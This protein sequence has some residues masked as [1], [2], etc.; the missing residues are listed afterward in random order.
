M[1]MFQFMHPHRKCDLGGD[2][3][4]AL[5]AISTR[6]P[7]TG[8]DSRYP[9]SRTQPANFNSRT[10]YGGDGASITPHAIIYKISIKFFNS[11]IHAGCAR[12]ANNGGDWCG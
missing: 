7:H 10:P 4:Q 1:P 8:Y 2:V 12:Q 5:Q 9:I 6:T 11:R 3:G